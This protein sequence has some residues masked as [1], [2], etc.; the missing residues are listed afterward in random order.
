MLWTYHLYFVIQIWNSTSLQLA[1][2]SFIHSFKFCGLQKAWNDIYSVACRQSWAAEHRFYTFCMLA[3]LCTATARTFKAASSTQ[4]AGRDYLEKKSP[5]ILRLVC[6]A[7][8]RERRAQYT[9]ISCMVHKLT[10][11]CV[12]SW[13]MYVTKGLYKAEYCINQDFYPNLL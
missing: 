2:Q 3:Q 6:L 11:P 5:S 4:R 9:H 8:P 13:G 1:F 12:E 10:H 7:V